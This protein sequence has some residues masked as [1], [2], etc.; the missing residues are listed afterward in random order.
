[1]TRRPASPRPPDPVPAVASIGVGALF[2]SAIGFALSW[3]WVFGS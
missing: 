3:L 1:M 2:G